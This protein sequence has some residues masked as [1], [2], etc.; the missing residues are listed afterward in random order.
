MSNGVRVWIGTD[1]DGS[2]R[3]TSG[4]KPKWVDDCV[5][6]MRE[7][8]DDFE[9][10]HGISVPPG[11]CRE[12]ILIPAD[13]TQDQPQPVAVTPLALFMA[14][15]TM[16]LALECLRLGRPLKAEEMAELVRQTTVASIAAAAQI[17]AHK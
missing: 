9:Q 5:F 10:G 11:E 2:Q 13:A 1:A 16:T 8:F 12:Y 3:I 6:D 15:K 17:E 4:P 14:D 7:P